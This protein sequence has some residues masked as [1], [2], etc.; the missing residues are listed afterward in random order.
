MGEAWKPR[1]AIG[2]GRC[3]KQDQ[4]LVLLG[5]VFGPDPL[6]RRT[7]T[8]GHENQ[9]VEA[10]A[11]EAPDTGALLAVVAVASIAPEERELEVRRQKP[12]ADPDS[13]HLPY[14]YQPAEVSEGVHDRCNIP[15]LGEEAVGDACQRQMTLYGSFLGRNWAGRRPMS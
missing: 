6:V 9:I 13:G 8:A 14:D 5:V 11:L 3:S 4:G 10:L 2:M 1:I 7:A 15:G 12:S